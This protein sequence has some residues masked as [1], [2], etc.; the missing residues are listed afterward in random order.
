[1][2]TAVLI[3]AM[4]GAGSTLLLIPAALRVGW[5]EV[6]L[7]RRT[8]WHHTHSR[9]VPRL[10]GAVLVVAFI[11]VEAYIAIFHSELRAETPAR[12]VLLSGSL[13]MFAL[14]FWDDL[15][16]LRAG[17]KLLGQ[18][19]IAATVSYCGVAIEVWTLP[20]AGTPIHLGA[21]GPVLT[22]AWLVTLTNL[23]NLIDGADGLA[24]GIS[25]ALMILIAAVAHQNGNFELLASGMAGALLGFLWYNFPPA[26]IYLGDGG[27]YFL[28]F[29]IGLYSL[30]NS[31]KGTIFAALV[32]PLFV[33]AFPMADA[34][35]TLARR[36]LRGLPLFRPDSKHLH[37]RLMAI[38][39]SGR[40]L[41]LW[42]YAFNV[43]FLL[44][45]LAAFW[46]RGQLVPTLLGA[47]VLLLVGCAGSFTF[48]R[49]WFAI[50]R[51]VRSSLRMRDQIQYALSLTRWLELEGRRTTSPD[52]LWPDFVF[53]ANKLGFVSLKVT[54][55]GEHRFWQRPNGSLG[56]VYQ[57]YDC[58]DRNYGSL[59]FMAP[60]CP[61][62]R[63]A[64]EDAA[65]CHKD[66]RT[67]FGE[68]LA[69]PRVFE[70]ISELL[71]ET[72]N[73]SG[74]QWNGNGVPLKF[75][76]PRCLETAPEDGNGFIQ[77]VAKLNGV[78]RLCLCPGNVGVPPTRL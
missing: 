67:N 8:D 4:L 72:W 61:L 69:D 6:L 2:G 39:C 76:R 68:C 1:M 27:A 32:A 66:C 14:G 71:A 24:G 17:W 20:L 12:N 65:Q 50:H 78:K 3:A 57:R 37:H 44:M 58:P 35:L 46:S 51:V 31:H 60:S 7:R 36:G 56:A 55:E 16:P 19:L 9:P 74:A 41:V 15:R 75:T 40:K 22:V 49:R 73:R 45:G 42:V 63:S 52:E 21:W 29:Q 33:L 34:F 64:L 59:E 26:R 11:I 43:I 62:H 13:A 23:I 53:A 5:A 10:G 30:V 48:S 38:G 47:A 54:L 28:G 18:I 70:T 25:L 77:P